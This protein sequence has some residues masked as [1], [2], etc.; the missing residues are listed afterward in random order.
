M[1]P[2]MIVQMP[3]AIPPII[4]FRQV[5]QDPLKAISQNLFVANSR[6]RVSYHF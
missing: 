3:V 1:F 6:R 4:V 5:G 2:N